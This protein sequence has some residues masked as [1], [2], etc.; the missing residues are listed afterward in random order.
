[1]KR[2]IKNSLTGLLVTALLA[3]LLAAC[4]RPLRPDSGQMES[5]EAPQATQPADILVQ[6]TPPTDEPATG[7]QG[8][9][10][11][12][13]DQGVEAPTDETPTGETPTG[14]TPTEAAPTDTGEPT[15]DATAPPAETNEPRA[16]VTHTVQ[17]GETLY[18]IA[19]QY[20]VSMDLLI[21]ANSL[22]DPNRLDVGD[23]ILVPLSG[24]LPEGAPT[25][26]PAGEERIHIVAAGDNLFRIGLLYGFTV[27]ELAKYNGLANP[28]ALE[29]GQEIRIPPAP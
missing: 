11:G 2:T 7:D 27:D 15:G 10:P 26:P 5:P 12:A 1:M 13:A 3:L 17:S 9:E 23:Q 4:E 8:T 20:G 16:D 18:S 28:T 21:Q 14:E 6:P 19:L 25:T 22:T 24:N 29:V